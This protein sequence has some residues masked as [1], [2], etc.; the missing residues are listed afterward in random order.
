MENSIL[1]KPYGDCVFI[2][3]YQAGSSSTPS[4][5]VVRNNVLSEPRRC[6]VAV[7]SGTNIHIQDNTITKTLS[8]YVSAIDLEPDPL[9]YQH[10]D[11]V[12]IDGNKLDVVAL[13]GAGCAVSMYDPPGNAGAP[14]CVD[15]TVTNNCGTW[16][17]TAAAINQDGI[18]N[19]VGGTLP[20][21][22]VS[23]SGNVLG[24]TGCGANP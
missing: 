9:G 3:Q 24:S 7:S 22:N 18:A 8:T 20:W 13:P 12:T 10:V 14:P 1:E 6:N 21:S 5:I 2:G 11:G 16:V 19:Y 23:I 17:P 15:V 4:G